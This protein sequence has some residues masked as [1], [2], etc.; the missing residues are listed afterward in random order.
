ME[1]DPCANIAELIP[2]L[3]VLVVVVALGI[4]VTLLVRKASRASLEGTR[5]SAVRWVAVGL[6]VMV[7]SGLAVLGWAIIT[8]TQMSRAIDGC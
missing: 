4:V 3:L 5:R 8:A 7:L 2:V 1:V 6:G